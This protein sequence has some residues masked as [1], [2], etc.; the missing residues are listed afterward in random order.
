M[1]K[2]WFD[3]DMVELKI[4]VSDGSSLFFTKVYVGY[5]TLAEAS[6]ALAAFRDQIYGGI[7]DLLFGEFGPEYAS[8]AF[9]ARLHFARPGKLYITCKMESE[10]A[11]FSVNKVASQATLFLRSEP[12][13]LDNF[14]AEMKAL[15]DGTREDASLEVTQK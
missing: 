15:N 6:S 5:A 9:A 7:Y 2:I 3:D 10:Y 11:E 1:T 8:G 4:E 13:L 14:I 12:I